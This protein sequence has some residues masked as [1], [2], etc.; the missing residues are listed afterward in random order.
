MSCSNP[1]LETTKECG[2]LP[3]PA[4]T[5]HFTVHPSLSR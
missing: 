5:I 3:H 4:T 1:L 2:C